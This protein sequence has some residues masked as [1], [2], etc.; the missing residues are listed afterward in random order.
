VK[1]GK[2]HKTQYKGSKEETE[3]L[4]AW[5]ASLKKEAKPE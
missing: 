2:K 4:S 5:L 3:T 1:D